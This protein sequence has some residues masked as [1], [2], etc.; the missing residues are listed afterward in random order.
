MLE[1]CTQ[2]LSEEQLRRECTIQLPPGNRVYQ[3]PARLRKEK[4]GGTPANPN[5][6]GPLFLV[7]ACGWGRCQAG[8]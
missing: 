5:N 6:L 1:P 3:V 7:R 4:E 2:A 8:V